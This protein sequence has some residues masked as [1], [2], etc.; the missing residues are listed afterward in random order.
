LAVIVFAVSFFIRSTPLLGN[1]RIKMKSEKKEEEGRK[2][3]IEKEN[4]KYS[5]NRIVDTL[6]EKEKEKKR[7]VKK[8]KKRKMRS[9][10]NS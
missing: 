3:E 5:H 6:K 2:G 8:K 10:E 4:N 7:S 9:Q 1:Q